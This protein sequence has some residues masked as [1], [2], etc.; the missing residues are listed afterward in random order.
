[1]YNNYAH[2]FCPSNINKWHTQKLSRF[3]YFVLMHN[4][5]ALGSREYYLSPYY[6]E[7][8]MLRVFWDMMTMYETL[9]AQT[10]L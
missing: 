5:V 7:N 1:M 4:K 2:A 3:R 10:Y 6:L 9:E 8:S